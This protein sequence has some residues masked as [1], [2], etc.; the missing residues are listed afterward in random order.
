MVTW[1]VVVV[2]LESDIMTTLLILLFAFCSGFMLDIVWAHC[3]ICVQSRQALEAANFSVLLY[4]F[5][6]VSTIFIVEKNILAVIAYAS[7]SWVGTYLIVSVKAGQ[8]K[9]SK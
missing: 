3:I 1:V 2:R 7:G 9:T 4:I 8:N 6:I 5:T